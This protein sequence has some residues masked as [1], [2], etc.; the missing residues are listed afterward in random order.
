MDLQTS[1]PADV[2]EPL[3]T[4][5][6]LSS[7]RELLSRRQKPPSKSVQI[8]EPRPL[9]ARKTQAGQAELPPA[10][11]FSHLPFDHD[12]CGSVDCSPFQCVRAKLPSLREMSKTPTKPRQETRD[13]KPPEEIKKHTSDQTTAPQPHP[14]QPWTCSEAPPFSET[15]VMEDFSPNKTQNPPS[16]LPTPPPS[17]PVRG[18]DKRRY[19]GGSPRS[20]S[21]SSSSSSSS[22]CASCSPKRPRYPPPQFEF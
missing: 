12:Y 4:E 10:H 7:E 17:P 13:S 2:P 14:E 22:S 20:D 18:R 9:P 16:I 15:A 1:A 6:V 11:V 5:V 19:R 21:S 3:G 8:I